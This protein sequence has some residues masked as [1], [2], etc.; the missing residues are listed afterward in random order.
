MVV[1]NSVKVAAYQ[2]VT[3]A[4]PRHC[5][6]DAV[7]KLVTPVAIVFLGKVIPGGDM[8]EFSRGLGHSIPVTLLVGASGAAQVAR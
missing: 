1:Q 3:I 5:I 4:C 2:I 7:H 8:R 6:N